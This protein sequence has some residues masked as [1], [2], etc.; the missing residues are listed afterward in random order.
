MDSQKKE[1]PVKY[2][3]LMVI[4]IIMIGFLLLLLNTSRWIASRSGIGNFEQ[5]IFTLRAPSIGTSPDVVWDFVWSN[6][7]SV[8]LVVILVTLLFILSLKWQRQAQRIIAII[9]ALGI[10]IL[11]VFTWHYILDELHVQAFLENQQTYSTFIQE[12]YV[13][14]R[15]VELVFP[16][17]ERNLIHIYLESVEVTFMSTEDGGA[18]EV[19]LIPELTALARE[20]TNFSQSDES[21]IGGAL[22]P[23]NTTW[24]SAGMF[25]QTAGLPLNVPV[26][27]DSILTD[28]LFLTYEDVPLFPSGITT[29]GGILEAQGYQQVIMMG[30]DATFG[31]RR[32]YFTEN[33]NYEIW[34]YH[35]AIEQGLIP[36]DYH[37]WWG[38]EDTKLFSF[39]QER[40]MEL[41]A[42]D[43]PF[44]FTM[45]TADT[46]F[47]DG[48]LSPSCE[49]PFT[50]QYA[51]VLACSS[52]QVYDFVRW[53]QEQPFYKNTTI[54]I[55]GDHLTMQS[56][57]SPF[58]GAF[59][60]PERYDRT[61][62][63]VFINPATL[64]EVT[65]NRTYTTM[66]L[67]PTILASLGVQIEGERLGLGTN[68]FSGET[69]LVERIGMEELNRK[70]Q[71][72]STFF[73]DFAEEAE[74]N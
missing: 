58:W 66:D 49:Q 38:F 71:L 22:T 50:E 62:Y 70:L 18:F 56:S 27:T 67:F 41:G 60:V 44:N 14:P 4:L 12:H 15:D 28:A 39:A 20:N 29:L 65:T 48:F 53:V 25:A 11:S 61:V 46:H 5:V 35:T 16:D 9:A 26:S 21:Q 8:I 37:V 54:V 42:S 47:E 51:N 72:R 68:L 63:T 10:A 34:D 55:T 33:G 74:G 32:G 69:T 43:Q 40:L 64:P 57:L 45:L 23:I 19:N 24:T 2:K 3:V 13:D 30:S 36:A 6:V 17:E 52:R 31:G 59:P 7:P 73:K 1:T